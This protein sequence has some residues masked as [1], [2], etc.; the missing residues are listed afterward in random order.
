MAI[1]SPIVHKCPF[2]PLE[3]RIIMVFRVPTQWV[4]IDISLI[5]PPLSIGFS[6]LDF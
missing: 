1:L 3:P 5:P 4:Q 6:Q 2:A